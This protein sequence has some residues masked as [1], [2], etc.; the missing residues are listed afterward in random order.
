MQ[1]AYCVVASGKTHGAVGYGR[2]A[3][4]RSAVPHRLLSGHPQRRPGRL[5]GSGGVVRVCSAVR[6]AEKGP[7]ADIRD[8]G[9]KSYKALADLRLQTLI[10]NRSTTRHA[11]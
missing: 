6:C 4:F 2:H 11:Q 9:A 8:I 1:R 7:T 10:K 3:P 5:S